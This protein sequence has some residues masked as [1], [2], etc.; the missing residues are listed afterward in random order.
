MML[1]YTNHT[2][3]ASDYIW[4]P[5]LSISTTSVKASLCAFLITVPWRSLVLCCARSPLRALESWALLPCPWYPESQALPPWRWGWMRVRVAWTPS[6]MSV[7]VRHAVLLLQVG[8][9]WWLWPHCSA[10]VTCGQSCPVCHLSCCKPGSQSHVP[11][12]LLLLRSMDL[13]VQLL[14]SGG[15]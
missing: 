13:G 3:A 10:A 15:P 12:P 2:W 7:V 5:A 4:E 9:K 8:R 14:R 1:Y 6:A 11:P